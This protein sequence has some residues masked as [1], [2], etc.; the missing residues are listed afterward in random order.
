[1]RYQR[2]RSRAG[3]ARRAF[4][5]IADSLGVLPEKVGIVS[6]DSQATP[7]GSG[8]RASRGTPVGGE[9]AL[10]AS[11]KLKAVVLEAAASL[12]GAC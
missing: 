4:Q 8:V 9:L 1:M 5:I 7:Y 12:A 3:H 6:G 10:Q 11:L 2:H